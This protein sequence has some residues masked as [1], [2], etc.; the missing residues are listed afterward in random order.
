MGLP[1][2]KTHLVAFDTSVVD[3]TSDVTDPAE[4]LMKVQLGGGTDIAR[5]VAYGAGLVENPR[6]TI[7]AVITDFYE[8][9]NEARLVREVRKLV[10]QGTHVLGL[11]ALDEGRTRRT[12]VPWRSGS[13]ERAPTSAP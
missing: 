6:R 10:Q 2:L 12:T 11:A 13:P 7:V 9:G 3:L 8:G 1:G 4:L 5:A